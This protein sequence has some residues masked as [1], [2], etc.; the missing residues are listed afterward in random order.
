MEIYVLGLGHVGLPL[1]CWIALAGHRVFGIDTD[2]ERLRQ[3][4]SGRVQIE[5]SFHGT[6]LSAL[7]QNLIESGQLELGTALPAHSAPAVFLICVGIADAP[8]G[9]KDLSPVLE[10]A[11]AAARALAPGDLVILRTTLIPSTCEKAVLPILF[12]RKIPF[13]FAYCPETIQETEAF[14]ELEAHPLILAAADET[15][16]NAA[17]SFWA[18]LG[19]TACVRAGSLRAAELAKVV[20][21][22][23]RDV[24]IAFASEMGRA[25]AGLGVDP[26]E[27]QR[28]V[29]VNPRV[30]M[31]T[32]GP[33]V[34]GYCLPNALSYL[35]AALPEEPLTLS[36][37]A[38]AVNEGQPA[39]IA[40]LAEQALGKQGKAVAGAKIAVAGLAMK[41]GCA[42]LRN[43]P[44]L[45]IVQELERRGAA[46]RAYDPLIAPVFP[47]QSPSLNEALSGADCLILA[48]R[49]K[50]LPEDGAALTAPMAPSPVIIDTQRILR[51]ADG[52]VLVRI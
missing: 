19:K 3:I 49:Q 36:R 33:G 32:A 8:G 1:A 5:E 12:S 13:S 52:A 34:G 45:A 48:A 35:R 26:E 16:E 39:R 23:H 25:A 29:N 41:S 7:A 51:R 10:A 9:V 21:N 17:L 40:D 46:V 44:S 42:D 15:S 38:R 31:L 18:L 4:R 6:P 28:L 27:L 22:L 50:G 20:Q 47:F 2:G 14:E 30:H 37:M 43:S 24:D 11:D